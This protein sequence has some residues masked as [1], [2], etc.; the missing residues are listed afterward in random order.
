LSLLGVVPMVLT[1][2]RHE[3]RVAV[4]RVLRRA[5]TDMATGLPNRAAFE[6]A[7]RKALAAPP[8]PCALVYLDLD[9]FTLVNDTASHAAGDALIHGVGSLLKAR[10]GAGDQVFR[11]GGD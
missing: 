4:R 1:A 7:T 11:I 6:E 2:A 10:V 3:S 5:T 8:A 9:N